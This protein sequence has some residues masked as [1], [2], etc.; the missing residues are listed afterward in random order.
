[1]S[2]Q[3]LPIFDYTTVDKTLVC[4]SNGS[5][6]LITSWKDSQGWGSAAFESNQFGEQLTLLE[7]TIGSMPICHNWY[8]SKVEYYDV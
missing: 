5:Y 4:N 3:E 1:M 7:K 2:R 8:T 6:I